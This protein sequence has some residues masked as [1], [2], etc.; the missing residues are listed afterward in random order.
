MKSP[1]YIYDAKQNVLGD[2]V[3]TYLIQKGIDRATTQ[4]GAT[5]TGPF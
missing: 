4:A 5:A 2:F 1:L 3:S